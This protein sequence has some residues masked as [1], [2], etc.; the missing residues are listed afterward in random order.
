MSVTVDGPDWADVL[1]RSRRA[2]NR[3]RA[4]QAAAVLAVVVTGVASAYALGH[5]VIDFAKAKHA[6]TRQVNDFGSMEVAAPRG[7]APGVLPHQTRRITSVLI[8]G[9]LRTLYVAPTKQGGFCF[10]WYPGGGCRA[11]RHDKYASHIDPGGLYGA[12]ALEVLEG[13]F[14]QSNG[15]HLTITFKD[16]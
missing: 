10:E 15:D 13:T 2:T 12:H 11:N 3:V 4:V 9:K 8:D 7:M 5:P 16:G 14:M 1:R 6:G